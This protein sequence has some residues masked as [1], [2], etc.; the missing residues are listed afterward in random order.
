MDKPAALVSRSHN[1]LFFMF[2]LWT[3]YDWVAYCYLKTR[4]N[5]KVSSVHSTYFNYLINKSPLLQPCSGL[6]EFEERRQ[7]RSTAVPT[8]AAIPST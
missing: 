3:I 4:I 2:L 5:L 1:L 8:T 6:T 7:Y